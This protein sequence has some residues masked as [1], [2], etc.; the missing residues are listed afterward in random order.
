MAGIEKKGFDNAVEGLFK[1][2]KWA[3]CPLPTGEGWGEGAI[4]QIIKALGATPVFTTAKAHDEAVA[5]ISH[6]PMVVSQALFLAA[7]ENP[8]ALELASSG[9]RD[10][11]R[12][13]LSNEEMA[14]DMV[15]MNSENIQ[16][17]ILKLYSAL[18]A[19]MTNDYPDL[20]AKIKSER[21]KMF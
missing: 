1:G 14:M 13:A 15:K 3:I 19:L 17:S 18:G 16:N 4:L 11:T 9:F 6:M 12:L 5:M 8:L 10:M 7:N 2:A 21:E 20:I